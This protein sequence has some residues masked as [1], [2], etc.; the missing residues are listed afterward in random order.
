MEINPQMLRGNWAQGWAL[1]LH[2][3]RSK[4]LDD[5]MFETTRTEIGEALYQLKYRGD[6]TQIEPI[7]RAAAEFLEKQPFFSRLEAIIPVPPS[8]EDRRFQPVWELASA[9][10]K[11]L[12]LAVPLGYL[13][14]VK[15]TKALKDEKDRRSRKE[16]LAGAFRVKDQ[17]F[18]RKW[19]LLFD[20]LFRSGQTLNEIAFVLLTQG[21]VSGVFVL[22]VTKTR[23]KR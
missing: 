2:T 23:T 7:A 10:A 6:R 1:D 11:K 19:V 20:D 15:Q 9:I 12:D 4:P 22:T 3:V 16:E 21:K 18:A 8:E 13:I 14:K 5:G 17:R